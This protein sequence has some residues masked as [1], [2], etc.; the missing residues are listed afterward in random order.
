MLLLVTFILFFYFLLLILIFFGWKKLW[1]QKPPLQSEEQ[2][3]SVV[4]PV[5]N[6][7]HNMLRILKD[8]TRQ[9]YTAF[10]IIVI[11]DHS[12][13]RTDELVREFNSPFIKCIQNQGSGKKQA[14]ATGVAIASGTIIATTDA[15]C[16]LPSTWLSVINAYLQENVAMVIG[17][18]AITGEGT[19]FSHMQQIEFSSLVGTSASMLSLGYP[20]MCNGANLAYKKEVF[21]NLNGYEGNEGVPSGDD[22]FLMRKVIASYPNGLR[23]IFET[24]AVVKTAPQLSFEKFL[25]QRLRWAAKWRY[26]TSLTTVMLA[27]FLTLVQLATIF[28]FTMVFQL[29]FYPWLPLIFF[30]AFLEVIILLNFCR[31]LGIRWNW[32]AF[33]LLFLF[34]P[35]YVLY[36]ALASNFVGYSWRGRK[37]RPS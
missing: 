33:S 32:S 34:Y 28:C 16:S 3:I 14:I 15:D 7:E 19:L 36:V 2:F 21:I 37:Y 12:E 6:E 30:K 13:D 10:E 8:L 26:N 31:F 23:Y 11:N 24:A 25:E 29:W 27:L 17:P 18:V 9:Q 4:L 5:R 20:A 22:E 35:I 1:G